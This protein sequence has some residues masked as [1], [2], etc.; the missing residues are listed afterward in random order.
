MSRYSNLS[1]S[2]LERMLSESERLLRAD[3]DTDTDYLLHNLQLH[4][5]E[6]EIQNRDL[7]ES[8]KELENI[9]D[10]YAEL[11]DFAPV[12][13]LTLDK[14]GIINNLNISAAAMFGAERSRIVGRP[15][16]TQL[17]PGMGRLLFDHLRHAFSSDQKV[18]A[19][20]ALKT[21]SDGITRYVRAD[22]I[23]HADN[24]NQ[25]HCLMNLIDTTERR[26]AEQAVIDERTFLQHVIDGVENPIMVISLDFKVLRMNE[27]AKR[28]ATMQKIDPEHACCYQISHQVDRPC[29]G[30]DYPCPLKIVLQTRLPTKV[31]HNHISE[32]GTQRKYEVSVS[33]LFDDDGEIMG[34]IESSHDITEHLELLD[35]LKERQLSYAH[36][37]QHDALTGLPNRLL[38]ADRLS[39]AIHVAHRNKSMLAVLFI[40]LD[41][42][43][44]VNDSFNHATGDAVL[45][46]VAERFQSLFRE[47]DTIARM[48]GDEFTV[49]LT[50]IK[51][52]SNA[53]LVAKKLLN[54]FKKPFTIQNH[55]LYLTASIGISL[56][57]D[58]GESVDELVR[59]ADTAMYR[60]KEEGRNTFQYYT[61]ELTARAFERVFLASSLHNAISQNELILHYQPQI[62]LI[63]KEICGVEALV[64]WQ[65]RDLGLLAP[66]KFIPLAEESEVIDEMGAW[67]MKEA[68][69]QMKAWQDSGILRSDM[70]I[71]VNLSGKQFDHNNLLEEIEQTLTATGLSPDCLELEIT[72]TTMM[73]ST[74]VTSETLRKLRK[75]GVK[76]AVDDFGT[77]YSSLNYLK[78]LPITRL[79]IDKT[80]ISDIPDDLNDVAISK[81]IIAMAN[82][83]L[84]DVLAE[85]IETGEQHQ[86]L[87][88]QGCRVGQ[89]YLFARPMPSDQ[90]ESFIEQTP[91]G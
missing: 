12:G 32:F 27:A 64:R 88:Q 66:D 33:P 81:A 20:L 75:L 41:R 77:G 18:T 67:I 47:D 48:G 59:N 21:T 6:L 17:A 65:N 87:I 70:T 50:H 86:F 45:K 34:V 38:F 56:Y 40:D 7:M 31:T 23:V 61:L 73:R 60:A 15:L 82:N 22:T 90:F 4:K 19:D 78:Q 2:E 28:I 62:E 68:C 91:Q 25:A 79:K 10:Q 11:Y 16:S 51:K 89:G 30:D 39:Q 9:R 1:H 29:D 37:A 26:R 80:F 42:F 14:N 36:L 54:L 46:E 83:L 49:I 57:P 63:T 43:K 71:S 76:V 13:Y 24:E 58:H 74:S 8:Q 84:L 72:E 55:K 52:D 3:A 69:Q 85:G 44:E 5:I 53:A 35:E